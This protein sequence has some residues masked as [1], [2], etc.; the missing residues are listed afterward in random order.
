MDIA[1]EQ[2]CSA[3]SATRP[4]RTAGSRRGSSGATAGSSSPRRGPTASRPVRGQAH[5]RC[6]PLQQYLVP[7]PRRPAAVPHG[8]LGHGEPAV[9]PLYPDQD[10]PA[11][12][13]LHWTRN[14]QNWN[15][16]CAECHSTNLVKGYDAETDTYDTTWSEINVGCEACHGPGVAARRVGERAADGT[17]P[18]TRTAASW[19]RPRA[20]R[21]RNSSSSARRA[22][23]A[24]PSSATTTTRAAQLL[25]HLR[26]VA[27]RPRGSTT[28]TASTRTRSTTTRRSC[29]ARCTR[30]ACA[31]ATAT[32]ATAAGC[33]SEGNES[34]PAV[35]PARGLRHPR[36]PLPQEGGGREAVATARSASSATW[37]SGRTWWWTGAPITASAARGPT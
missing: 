33:C 8:R 9:V 14:A 29:R 21:P 1:A 30:A 25:D 2:R 31:A 17:A 13:W 18:L 34:V 16:M 28:P 15:G 26:A 23:R 11:S 4:S 24:A 36:P 12:D 22:T 32:T 35:P 20:S 3:T 5:V 27:A 6:P 7:V 19:C 37:P 10:V